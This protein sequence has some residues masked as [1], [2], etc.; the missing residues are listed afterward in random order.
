[1]IDDKAGMIYHITE[2]MEQYMQDV[3]EYVEQLEK[4]GIKQSKQEADPKPLRHEEVLSEP[5]A[6]PLLP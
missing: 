6:S 2:K 4:I 3:S 5:K 1:M